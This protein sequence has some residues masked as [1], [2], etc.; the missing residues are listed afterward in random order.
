MKQWIV[1]QFFS[2]FLFVF[3]MLL[4]YLIS[5]PSTVYETFGYRHAYYII[6][7][8]ILHIYTHSILDLAVYCICEDA[9]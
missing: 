4:N 2:R 7:N 5:P 3:K 8:I 1:G 6:I 9:G